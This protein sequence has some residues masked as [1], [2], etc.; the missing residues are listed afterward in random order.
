MFDFTAKK[1]NLL[2][3][4]TVLSYRLKHV[5]YDAVI[6]MCNLTLADE[7]LQMDYYKDCELV[8]SHALDYL[9]R[10]L[11]QIYQESITCYSDV[12]DNFDSL[13]QA[14]CQDAKFL[15]A[16]GTL[17]LENKMRAYLDS[18]RDILTERCM[19]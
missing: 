12:D 10:S 19:K 2:H 3:D 7:I 17:D 9:L 1:K 18:Y 13:S 14:I 11:Y 4:N 8:Q 6:A 5:R 16:D 15:D